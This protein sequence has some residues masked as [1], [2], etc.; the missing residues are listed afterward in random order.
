M[1]IRLLGSILAAAEDHINHLL[2]YH[3][4][5]LLLN[6]VQRKVILSIGKN[7]FSIFKKLLHKTS[8]DNQIWIQSLSL[9]SLIKL[10]TIPTYWIVFTGAGDHNILLMESSMIYSFISI[11][12][13]IIL[14]NQKRQFWLSSLKLMIPSQQTFS[15][16]FNFMIK[17][18]LV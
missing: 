5:N 1:K 6:V 14:Q 8:K 3:A 16:I 4:N 12:C 2:I 7:L 10:M 13:L 11:I 18:S 15:I 9:D 17:N